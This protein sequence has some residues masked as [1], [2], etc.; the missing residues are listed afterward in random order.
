M[1]HTITISN[2]GTI[3]ANP[4][5]EDEDAKLFAE[6]HRQSTLSTSNK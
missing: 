6:Y 1:K 3:P 5:T 2:I 4:D